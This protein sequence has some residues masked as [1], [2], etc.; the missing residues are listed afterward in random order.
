MNKHLPVLITLLTFG[1]FGVVGDE[2][3]LVCKGVVDKIEAAV[4]T[5]TTNFNNSATSAITSSVVT[6]NRQYE[7][8]VF[9]NIELEE[10]KGTL[11]VPETMRSPNAKLLKT[12]LYDIEISEE[13]I[14]AR[15]KFNAFARHKFNIDRRTGDINY[16]FPDA[17][18]N[19]NCSKFEEDKKKF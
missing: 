9:I 13:K 16:S 5:S 2:L 11:E 8:S 4:G 3:N 15:A 7:A 17:K 1:S 14:S 10:E 19:G 12:D 6:K 18:F